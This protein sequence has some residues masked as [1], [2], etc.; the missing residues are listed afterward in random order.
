MTL[1]GPF[2]PKLLYDSMILYVNFLLRCQYFACLVFVYFLHCVSLSNE[3]ALL[4][5]PLE[6]NKSL[7]TTQFHLHF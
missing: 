2:Q 5:S 4:I 1:K 6:C 3:L 7:L